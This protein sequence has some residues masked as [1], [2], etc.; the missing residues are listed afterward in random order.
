MLIAGLQVALIG[1][2]PV[3][4]LS[5]REELRELLGRSPFYVGD[6]L[7]LTAETLLL[8]LQLAKVGLDLRDV[9]RY[10]GLLHPPEDRVDPLL[11]I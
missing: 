2:G 11:Y 8:F 1:A 3:G 5:Q 7:Q 9:Y 6:G 10:P 4:D